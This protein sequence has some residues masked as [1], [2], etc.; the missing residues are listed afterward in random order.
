MHGMM[1]HV[2]DGIC[3]SIGGKHPVGTAYQAHGHLSA[4]AEVFDFGPGINYTGYVEPLIEIPKSR[5][6]VA[7]GWL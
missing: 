5:N 6:A 3:P 2:A 4:V 7:M 1:D